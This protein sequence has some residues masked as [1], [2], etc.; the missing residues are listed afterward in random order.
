MRR[1]PVPVYGA[2]VPDPIHELPP[3]V[4]LDR[5][6]YGGQHEALEVALDI[7]DQHRQVDPDGTARGVVEA[8][9]SVLLR[10]IWPFLEDLDDDR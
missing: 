1:G 8:A 5:K 6:E 3:S 2:A 10:K 7:L 4:V 9:L